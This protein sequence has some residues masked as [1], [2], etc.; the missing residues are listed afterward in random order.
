[1][2]EQVRG[3]RLV[4]VG[5]APVD[6][7]GSLLFDPGLHAAEAVLHLQVVRL[8]VAPDG[9]LEPVPALVQLFHDPLGGDLVGGQRRLGGDDLAAG[10]GQ[11]G[12]DIGIGIGGDG[13]V[14]SARGRGAHIG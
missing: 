1:M 9:S 6:L 8:V 4:E 7:V 5:D 10:V 13:V 12:G 11:S 3:G 2:G 14:G